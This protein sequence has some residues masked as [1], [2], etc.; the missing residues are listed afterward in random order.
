[1][2]EPWEHEREVEY[3]RYTLWFVYACITYSLIGF[4]WGVLMGGIPEFRYFVDHRMHGDTIAG[5][6]GGIISQTGTLEEV[7][8]VVKPVLAVM[9]VFGTLVLLA[10]IIWAYN[11]FKTCAGW[12]KRYASIKA[13][14]KA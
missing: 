6:A 1:M 4:T 12:E 5:I 11:L 13:S 8:A 3:R 7:E 2:S 14:V 9:G 10:N